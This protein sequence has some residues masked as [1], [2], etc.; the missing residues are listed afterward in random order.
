M[1][2]YHIQHQPIIF[3]TEQS[4]HT[5]PSYG[6][7]R[8]VLPGTFNSTGIQFTSNYCTFFAK[9]NASHTAMYP[10]TGTKEQLTGGKQSHS[11]FTFANGR[12]SLSAS[13]SFT[14]K[15]YSALHWGGGWGNGLIICTKLVG[16]KPWI[17][18][19]SPWYQFSSTCRRKMMMSPL[20]NL[21]SPGSFPS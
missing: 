21:R 2:W 17:P 4:K 19:T 9:W 14:S 13:L 16:K 18:L 5:I 3:H 7:L 15:S 20:L 11:N 8:N 12:Q 6:T 10:G 1:K